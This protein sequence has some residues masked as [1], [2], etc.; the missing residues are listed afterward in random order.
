MRFYP[1]QTRDDTWAVA[2][3]QDGC[4]F[5]HIWVRDLTRDDA[6]TV[7]QRLTAENTPDDA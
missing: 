5:R 4:G 6:F 1:T 2:T 3:N 7:A